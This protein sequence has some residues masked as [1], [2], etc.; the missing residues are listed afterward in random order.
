MCDVCDV[1]CGVVWQLAHCVTAD[2]NWV[3]AG[4]CTALL[5]TSHTTPH[6]HCPGLLTSESCN[7]QAQ[8]PN[9]KSQ[10]LKFKDL[11]FGWH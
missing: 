6:T 9:P 10:V 11:D 8:S 7:C 3:G 4:L 2:V 1:W 5:H